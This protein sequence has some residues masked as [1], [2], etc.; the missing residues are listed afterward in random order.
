[1]N[2]FN[3][4]TLPTS[5]LFIR[6][7]YCDIL[8]IRITTVYFKYDAYITLYL[9]ICTIKFKLIIL[10]L[11]TR[12]LDGVCLYKYLFFFVLNIYF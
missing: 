7:R 2:L 4:E 9:L 11:H 12:L 6:D 3:V 5:L 8:T 10:L 1:M